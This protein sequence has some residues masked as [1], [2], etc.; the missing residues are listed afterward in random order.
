AADPARPQSL[1]PASIPGRRPT[2][3]GESDGARTC[4]RGHLQPAKSQTRSCS[5]APAT[6]DCAPSSAAPDPRGG[7]RRRQRAA[8]GPRHANPPGD[9]NPMAS[10]PPPT[11][12]PPAPVRRPALPVHTGPRG[13]FEALSR[14]TDLDVAAM[15]TDAFTSPEA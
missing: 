3:P 4:S 2:S 8:D 14:V 15:W 6:T 13:P 9:S 7:G 11:G 10:R 5:T 12:T 1:R